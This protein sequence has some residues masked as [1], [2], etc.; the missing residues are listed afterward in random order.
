MRRSLIIFYRNP[1]PFI[2]IRRS[3]LLQIAEPV[4]IQTD[5]SFSPR[6]KN[7][8]RTA[9]VLIKPDGKKFSL[10]NIY[11]DHIN[12]YE[13]EWRS[14]LDG[15]EYGLKKKSKSIN[16]ENDNLAVMNSLIRREKPSGLYD[17]YYYLI[18]EYIN[19]LEY[20]GIRWIPRNMNK[21]DKLFRI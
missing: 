21:A 18:M 15:I 13:S 16:L 11:F 8:S 9:V 1:G 7:L 14:V 4:H 6:N 3:S 17:D 12:S 10:S 2:T 19:K 20:L 5:G